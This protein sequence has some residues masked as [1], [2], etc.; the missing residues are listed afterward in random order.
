MQDRFSARNIGCA[1]VRPSLK[2]LAMDCPSQDAFLAFVERAVGSSD[3]AAIEAHL[4]DCRD[5]RELWRLMLTSRSTAIAAEMPP[6]VRGPLD[7]SAS[8]VLRPTPDDS[9]LSRAVREVGGRYELQELIGAGAMGEVYRAFDPRL[10]RDVALKL[11]RALHHDDDTAGVNKQMVAEAHTLARLAHPNVIAIFDSGMH[12]GQVFLAMELGRETLAEW[13]HARP[14]DLGERLNVLRQ[15]GEGL[16]AAHASGIVHRDVKPAN[17]LI[18][19]DGRARMTDFGLA[20]GANET[21]PP[22]NGPLDVATVTRTGL[23]IGTPAYMALEQLCGRRADERSDQFSFCVMAFEA[24]TGVRP[25]SATTLVTLREQIAA[26]RIRRDAAARLPRWL[27]RVILR[28]LRANPK[29]RWRDMRAMLDAIDR[30]P[31]LTRPRV[32]IGI[33]IAGALMLAVI[34]G[35]VSLRRTVRARDA[36]E[37]RRNELIILQARGA[38][39]SD[40]TAA[41]AWL[42]QLPPDAQN[43]RDAIPVALDAQSRGVAEHVLRRPGSDAPAL[44]AAQDGKRFAVGGTNPAI[45]D[46]DGHSMVLPGENDVQAVAYSPDGAILAVGRGD[47]GIALLNVSKVVSRRARLDGH[48]GA[49]LGLVF[50]RD[51][52]T[53]ASTGDDGTTRLWHLASGSGRL[54]GDAG[55]RCNRIAFSTDEQLLATSCYGSLIVVWPLDGGP[56]HRL[57]TLNVEPTV[58]GFSRDGCALIVGGLNAGERVPLSGSGS[59]RFW[60]R[61]SMLHAQL[62]ADRDLLMSAGSDRSLIL[63]SVEH[64]ASAA[65]SWFGPDTEVRALTLTPDGGVAVS[66]EVDGTLRIWRL[67]HEGRILRWLDVQPDS[68]ASSPDGTRLATGSNDGHAT[69]W[70]RTGEPLQTVNAGVGDVPW[71]EFTPDGLLITIDGDG[72]VI[73]HGPAGDRTLARGSGALVRA[74]LAPKGDL[75]AWV[76]R[77]ALHVRA[78]AAGDDVAFDRPV[79]GPARVAFTDGGRLLVF[80]CGGSVCACDP[81][82]CDKATKWSAQWAGA[83]N[84]TPDGDTVVAA[85]ADHR[86]QVFDGKGRL[87][88]TLGGDLGAVDRLVLSRDGQWVATGDSDGTVRLWNIVSGRAERLWQ[89]ELKISRLVFTPDGS[90]LVSASRDDTVRVIDLRTRHMRILRGQYNIFD[91]DVLPDSSG[92]VSVAQDR[93]IRLWPLHV[94]APRFDSRADLD[95]WLAARMKRAGIAMPQSRRR[96]TG[97]VAI[98][99]SRRWLPGTSLLVV[100]LRRRAAQAS[101]SVMASARTTIARRARRA[102]HGSYS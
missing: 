82:H 91:I 73:L 85:T 33:V 10:S 101:S 80:A 39:A 13:V 64:D 18:G 54:L 8:T 97:E 7:P 41:L 89:H 6:V 47:G 96:R 94:A 57:K 70:S 95:Q 50:S 3:R 19:T 11:L 16:A 36:A 63:W 86:L 31:P 58:A 66:G 29:E 93:T 5:C 79:S 61:G 25:F 28:G 84:A 1:S 92:V 35:L 27:R 42:K 53:L 72:T 9:Q 88:E 40:P 99:R 46:V 90:A 62:A 17:V 74:S 14:R 49:V 23:L 87:R 15:A 59:R 2:I 43:W 76:D 60:E 55:S 37:A 56:P 44:A 100:G 24:L 20:L 98:P 45:F 102:A 83:L 52:K 69:I 30:G 21:T 4:A 78:L 38:L 12:E 32:I 75:V 81:L 68:I 67:S 26:E 48:A 22:A 77:K 51:G 65:V 34:V 71:L